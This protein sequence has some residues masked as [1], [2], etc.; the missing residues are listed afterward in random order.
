MNREAK[1]ALTVAVLDSP[2]PVD[3]DLIIQVANHCAVIEPDMKLTWI[4]AGHRPAPEIPG[5]SWDLAIVLRGEPGA[6][7]PLM[8]VAAQ[9]RTP[10]L[11]L[12]AGK[13]RLDNPAAVPFCAIGSALLET[14]PQLGCLELDEQGLRQAP[15]VGAIARQ[16]RIAIVA[17]GNGFCEW[18]F[19]KPSLLAMRTLFSD[20]AGNGMARAWSPELVCFT[21]IPP[22]ASVPLDLPAAGSGAHVIE[23]V[24][25]ALAWE[26]SR[27]VL[28]PMPADR[29]LPAR[30]LLVGPWVGEFG[31]QLSRWQGGVRRLI[32]EHYPDHYIIVAGD[33]GHEALYEYAHEYWTVPQMTGPLGLTRESE[34]LLPKGRAEAARRCL[35]AALARL[36]ATLNR[37]VDHL[38]PRRFLPHEQQV[39]PV[40]ASP[41]A[42]RRVADVIRARGISQW[43]C[44]FP[45]QRA[46][47]PHKNWPAEAWRRLIDH[48]HRELGCGVIGMGGV[49]DTLQLP[50]DQDWFVDATKMAGAGL[51]LDSAF[52]AQAVGTIGS[53]SGGPFFSLLCRCPTLVLGGPV[54]AHRYLEEENPL[55]TPCRYLASADFRHEVAHVMRAVDDFFGPRMSLPGRNPESI[56]PPAEPVGRRRLRIAY[57][58]VFTVAHSDNIGHA[59]GFEEL[60]HTVIRYDFRDRARALGSSQKMEQEFGQLLEK[61]HVDIAVLSKFE[62]ASPDICQ[63]YNKFT[64][65]FFWWPDWENNAGMETYGHFAHATWSSCT[66]RS[67]AAS[68]GA[69]VGRQVWHVFDGADPKIFRPV[70]RD[71]QWDYDI[72]FIG[73]RSH[74]RARL[75]EVLE[76]NGYRC[77]FHGP[78]FRNPVYR[79]G[80]ATLCSSAKVVL[81]M[82]FGEWDGLFFSVR[83]WMTLACGACFLPE[84]V[85][86]MEEVF[87]NH[88]N[89]AWW[90]SDED[91]LAQLDRYVRKDSGHERSRIGRAGRELMLNSYTWRHTAQAMLSIVDGAVAPVMELVGSE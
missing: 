28:R 9:A 85:T 78:G 86:G 90:R 32:S 38:P 58:G 68:I 10:M 75:L 3:R 62:G 25:A 23:D 64:R 47:N 26:I 89:V 8:N 67:V 13:Y 81:G 50:I 37:P 4:W 44:I 11:L 40:V 73:Q 45:R 83:A 55:K 19:R 77:G 21:P 29:E 87:T 61:E 36:L 82:N 57:A 39:V 56:S 46:L 5:L 65:T 76:K 51:D 12:L 53:E 66:G 59:D 24:R 22:P 18:H 2:E 72:A 16:D 42:R 1:V 17:A 74:R 91:L 15:S 52:L 30:I 71:P 80:F 49:D 43:F 79:E 88:Q 41:D 60:G 69:K 84:Y 48:L 27:T 20:D 63:R 33:A 31:W 14:Q 70:N 6:D 35:M 7:L 54:Y 34:R